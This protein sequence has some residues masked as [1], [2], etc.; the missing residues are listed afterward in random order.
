MTKAEEKVLKP[1]NEPRQVRSKKRAQ[2]IMEVTA[3]LLDKVG[4]DDLTTILITKEMGISVGSLYHYFPNKHAILHSIASSWLNEWDIVLEKISK[5]NVEKME[6]RAVV[7][8]FS[9]A[10]L[11][12]Y[13]H[14]RGILPL[15]QAM[16]AVPELRD[17]DEQH[18]KT[19]VK[20]MSALFLRMGIE[21][22]KQELARIST[23]FLEVTHAMLVIVLTQ[24]GTTAK[25]TIN[26]LN[27]FIY[28]L[29]SRYKS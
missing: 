1:R 11:G 12:V 16:Y 22:S 13:K 26:D 27:E 18:D 2:E 24:K 17:L 6:L 8:E 25:S 21:K 4:F 29:L 28:N 20:V 15:V 10:L 5:I 14:Q 23:I 9:T 19:V 7:N 3:Q